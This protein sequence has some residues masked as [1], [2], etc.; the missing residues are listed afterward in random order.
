VEYKPVT[1]KK[2][3]EAQRYIEK[4]VQDYVDGKFTQNALGNMKKLD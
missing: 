4:F 1:K 2:Q 3:R